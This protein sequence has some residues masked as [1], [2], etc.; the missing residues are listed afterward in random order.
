MYETTFSSDNQ[1]CMSLF[2]DYGDMT[3]NHDSFEDFER[4]WITE[5]LEADIHADNEQLSSFILHQQKKASRRYNRFKRR[6]SSRDRRGT[7][8]AQYWEHVD[9]MYQRG[10]RSKLLNAMNKNEI[11]SFFMADIY[12]VSDVPGKQF[13]APESFVL[14]E[15]GFT[16]LIE[17]WHNDAL[18]LKVFD[19]CSARFIREECLSMSAIFE[20]ETLRTYFELGKIRISI[21][22]DFSECEV[23]SL[24]NFFRLVIDEDAYDLLRDVTYRYFLCKLAARL[25][26]LHKNEALHVRYLHNM[27]A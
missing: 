17:P 23:H 21:N 4:E 14:D 7:L 2:A 25:Y 3:C 13:L 18:V 15:Y 10:E 8:K 19:E 22:P 26:E 24:E 12:D 11:K 6:T 16:K 20:L 1:I 5:E 9:K 27:Q